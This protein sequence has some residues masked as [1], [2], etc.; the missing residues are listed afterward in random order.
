MPRHD[1]MTHKWGHLYCN[2]DRCV[3]FL[4]PQVVSN[5]R[6]I[7][8]MR[9]NL[10]S[11]HHR[12]DRRSI[13]IHLY[14]LTLN[15]RTMQGSVL[16]C[17]VKIHPT[18]AAALPKENSVHLFFGCKRRELSFSENDCLG[19][20]TL[21]S[22]YGTVKH[23][24]NHSGLVCVFFLSRSVRCCFSIFH[25][26]IPNNAKLMVEA[27][28]FIMSKSRQQKCNLQLA[29]A[30]WRDFQQLL[31]L[32]MVLLLLFLYNYGAVKELHKMSVC[33]FAAG[34]AAISKACYCRCC[35]AMSFNQITK[36]FV[37]FCIEEKNNH[38]A[39]QIK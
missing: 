39:G 8:K 23:W 12:R 34:A 26:R 17:V 32:L 27:S 19:L 24:A 25:R 22:T 1:K 4:S 28:N 9:L 11:S 20:M 6:N 15:L 38:L 13:L 2:M 5:W 18:I 36:L 31:L 30:R 21:R 35:H 33:S 3:F 29:F 16:A 14:K 7:R 37:S 10:F